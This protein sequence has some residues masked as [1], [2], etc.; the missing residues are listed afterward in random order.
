MWCL[1]VNLVLIVRLLLLL[2]GYGMGFRRRAM[3]KQ[4][5]QLVG[6]GGRGFVCT[7]VRAAAFYTAAVPTYVIVVAA[8]FDSGPCHS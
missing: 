4:L 8:V 7:S 2:D 3:A 6:A 1:V 5:M